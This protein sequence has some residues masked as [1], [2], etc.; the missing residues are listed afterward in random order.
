MD[1]GRKRLN[2]AWP[3]PSPRYL[4]T[5]INLLVRFRSLSIISDLVARSRE[6]LIGAYWNETTEYLEYIWYC[7]WDTEKEL[8]NFGFHCRHNGVILTGTTR[9]SLERDKQLE[10]KARAQIEKE[11]PHVRGWISPPSNEYGWSF[12]MYADN[13]MSKWQDLTGEDLGCQSIFAIPNADAWAGSIEQLVLWVENRYDRN[14]LGDEIRKLAILTP[15]NTTSACR[16]LNVESLSPTELAAVRR[17]AKR[18]GYP[19]DADL[20]PTSACSHA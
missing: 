8:G 3:M 9:L 15:L 14:D 1:V 19:V 13:P 4:S 7:N 11:C 5:P 17:A 16:L 2:A 12:A 20:F 10:A 6:Q 18:A